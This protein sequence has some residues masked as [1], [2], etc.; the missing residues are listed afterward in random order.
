MSGG[1]LKEWQM[2]VQFK[3]FCN[4]APQRRKEIVP[5]GDGTR[6]KRYFSR[7]WLSEPPFR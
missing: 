2:I 7:S 3:N 4:C 5:S 1:Q 6:E